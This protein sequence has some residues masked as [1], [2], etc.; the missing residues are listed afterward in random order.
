MASK[1]T[2]PAGGKV[3]AES[4]VAKIFEWRRGFNA[5]HLIDIGVR[6]G[7]FRA[8]ADTPGAT[9]GEIAER[10]GYHAPYIETW[11]VT[12]YSF[13]LLDGEE[14][15]S[16]R[17]A[18]HIDEV[19]ATP[20][21]PRGMGGYVRLGTEFATE[22]HRACLD[23]FRTGAALPFQG[24][25]EAFSEAVAQGTFGLQV[26]S[27]Y[28]LLPELPGL[29]DTLDAGGTLVEVGCGSGVHLLQVAKAFPRARCVG[30]EIDPTGLAIARRAID[31]AGVADRID[32]VAGGIE[33][34]VAAGTADVVVLIEV[35]HEIAPEIRQRVIDG[36]H[37]AL[38]PGGWLLIVDETYPGSLAEAR[39]PEF[40][41]P[42]QTGFEELTWGNVVPTAE[43][44]E[45]LLRAAGF[46]GDIGREIV[47]EG[48]TVLTARK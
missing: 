15:R 36:C 46:D 19:L 21:H 10:L 48:F 22:D 3:T 32:L 24:R 35:L 27:A 42:V 30:V 41:F 28:K 20:G 43:E 34:E 26:M 13:G 31:A 1:D 38:R 45:T 44:Q 16:F 33:S 39:R 17:L 14:D 2:T 37:R 8:F 6:L 47:G 11:C 7:L 4:Q 5:M 12:A 25:D 29:K 23:A 18:P 9:A 40:L